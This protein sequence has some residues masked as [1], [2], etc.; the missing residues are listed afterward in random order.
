G[1]AALEVMNRTPSA[2]IGVVGLGTGAMAAYKRQSDR[3][4]FFEIDPMVDR[5]ARNPRRFTYISECASGP[6]RTVIG[7]ARLTLRDEAPGSYDL[8][9]IDAFSSDAIPAH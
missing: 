4:T 7:D 3:L 2:V 6:V 1:Q 9:M 8:L 5:W